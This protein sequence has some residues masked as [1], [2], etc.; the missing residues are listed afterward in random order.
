LAKDR[1]DSEL[2]KFLFNLGV[3][4][5]DRAVIPVF[6]GLLIVTSTILASSIPYLYAG[7]DYS[8]WARAVVHRA[9]QMTLAD[10]SV[11]VMYFLFIVS[12]SLMPEEFKS[13]EPMYR[14]WDVAI[15]DPPLMTF[16][17]MSAAIR[18]IVGLLVI[19]IIGS[20]YEVLLF[21][22]HLPAVPL[23]TNNLKACEQ[24]L[25]FFVFR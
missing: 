6:V 24:F 16:L 7:G 20:C 14:L 11:L 18:V 4:E 1:A 22:R 8:C 19:Y 10:I 13:V 17:L 15:G 25:P 21:F 23:P 12:N 2:R 3:T 5:V 9:Y